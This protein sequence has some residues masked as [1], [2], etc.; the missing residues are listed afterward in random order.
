MKDFMIL[1]PSKAL[2]HELPVPDDPAPE[3]P[4]PTQADRLEKI[5]RTVNA[6]GFEARCLTLYG[7]AY[8]PDGRGPWARAFQA[9]LD[10]FRDVFKVEDLAVLQ[11]GAEGAVGAFAHGH[12]TEDE[13]LLGD[14]DREYLASAGIEEGSD[15]YLRYLAARRAEREG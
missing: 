6:D 2:L 8:L 11:R 5:V 10:E 13:G 3:P 15:R 9:K 12:R 7:P 1:D 4:P 14:G